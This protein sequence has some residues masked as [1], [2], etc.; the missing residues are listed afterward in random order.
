MESTPAIRR[1]FTATLIYRVGSTLSYQM[2]MVAVG[3]HLFDIT[4]SV[5]SLGLL[6]LVELIPYFI[7]AL[8]AGHWVDTHSRRMI[9]T[10]SSVMHVAIGIFLMFVARGMFEP[11]EFYIYLSV[12]VLGVGR[13]LLRPAYQSI[14]GQVI[15]RDLTPKYSA[16][17]SSA[18]QACVV[19]GPA[20]AGILIA[21]IG[22]DF[23]YCIAGLCALLGQYGV[24]M[25]HLKNLKR[26]KNTAPFWESFKESILYVKNHRL[27]LSAMSIDM[28]AVLFGGAVSM[29]PAFVKEILHQG[30]ETLGIL[31]AAPAIGA[32]LT[33]FYFARKPIL[34][35]S[36]KYVL[37]GVAGFGISMI[38]FSLST[39]IWVSAFFL[40]LSG[41]F[42]SV[43]VVVRIA[44]FQLTSPDH[45]RG[46]ISSINGIFV[47]SSNELGALES[48][49]AASVLGLVPSIAFGGFV[50]LLVAIGFYQFCTPIRNLHIQ[51]LLEKKDRYD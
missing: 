50:T 2:L 46:R 49:V 24:F 17:A 36:G 5:M 39:T 43:S 3:W 51:D 41:C 25:V 34:I 28:L 22:L 18:F 12:A 23:T 19:T 45:M 32:I 29:L 31:R 33:G 8:F 9:A 14:F 1:D 6:G 27:I 15:P 48:G 13:A 10:I 11:A 20:L 7:F 47:G 38:C 30:P 40:F 26:E 37:V 35:N 21:T 16:Y 4:N 42:D 44:I